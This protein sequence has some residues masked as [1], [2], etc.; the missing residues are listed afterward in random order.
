MQGQQIQLGQKG[1]GQLV[2]IQVHSICEEYNNAYLVT[3][4]KTAS[5]ATCHVVDYWL[6]ALKTKQIINSARPTQ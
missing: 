2:E 3:R 1:H 4:P 6:A 5:T